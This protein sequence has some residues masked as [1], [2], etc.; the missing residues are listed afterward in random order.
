MLFIVL[1]VGNIVF[2]MAETGYLDLD[3]YKEAYEAVDGRAYRGY[4]ESKKARFII[5]LILVFIVVSM[6]APWGWIVVSQMIGDIS[7]EKNLFLRIQ[8]KT[9]HV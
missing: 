2:H 5:S 4:L 8:I 6:L 3:L 1:T 7:K 9:T